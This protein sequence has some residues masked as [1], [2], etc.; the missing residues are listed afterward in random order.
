MMTPPGGPPGRPAIFD[1]QSFVRKFIPFTGNYRNGQKNARGQDL[2]AVF[3]SP[4]VNTQFTIALGHIP[5]RVVQQ[6]ATVGGVVF[7]PSQAAW[8]SIS[9][10]LQASVAGT[11]QLLVT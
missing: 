6:G 11:Y 5:T 4:N 8:S 9:I 7:A 2:T 1:I 10:T 3:A